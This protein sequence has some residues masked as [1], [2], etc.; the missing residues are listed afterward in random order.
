MVKILVVDDDKA[1][2]EV[3][4]II[5]EQNNFQ[6]IT[7]KNKKEID[8]ALAT[9]NP[10]LVLLDI[11][12]SGVNGGDLTRHLKASPKHKNLPIVL[13]SAD[14]NIKKIA[15]DVGANGYLEKP[16]DI[17]TLIQIVNTYV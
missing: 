15:T 9:Y 1:I 10:Q 11:S 16:F 14:N 3:V 4:K 13:L 2:L 6:V 5:L 8:E 17:E 12:I 7:A